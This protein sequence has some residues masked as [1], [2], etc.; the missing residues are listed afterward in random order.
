LGSVAKTVGHLVQRAQTMS[1]SDHRRPVMRDPTLFKWRCF[2]GE[3]ILPCV[4]WY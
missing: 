1:T 4:R 2:E 3:V